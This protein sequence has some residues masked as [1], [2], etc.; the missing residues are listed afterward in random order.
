L[1]LLVKLLPL[2]HHSAKGVADSVGALMKDVVDSVKEWRVTAPKPPVRVYPNP[3]VR[4]GMMHLGWSGEA[5]TYSVAFLD[6]HRQMKEGRVIVVGA[7]GQVDEWVVPNGLAAGVYFFRV[8]R[9]GER[10]VM[11][12]VLIQ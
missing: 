1:F 8:A 5:G 4:G 2:R 10:A 3:A 7:R 6:L 12:E 9:M 11:V